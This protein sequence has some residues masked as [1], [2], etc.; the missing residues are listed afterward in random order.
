MKSEL[1]F[2]TFHRVYSHRIAVIEALNE[3][4]KPSGEALNAFKKSTKDFEFSISDFANGH[5]EDAYR[6]FATAIKI[7]VPL[8]EWYHAVRN[9]EHEA[10]RFLTSANLKISEL[11]KSQSFMETKE[12]CRFLKKVSELEDFNQVNELQEILKAW[13]LPLILFASLRPARL[14]ISKQHSNKSNNQK[15]PLDT[16]VAFLK[17]DID[18]EPAKKWN[19]LKPNLAYDLTIEVR[20]SNWPDNAKQ[21]RLI[22]ITLD[23]Y[24]RDWLPEFTFQ[25]P[26]GNGPHILTGTNRALLKTANSFGSRP[27]EFLYA[28]EFDDA[29]TGNRVE[30]IGHRRLLIEGND[31]AS[32]PLTGFTNVDLQLLNIRN[33]LRSFPGLG[34]D[35]LSNAMTVLGGLGSIAGNA[36]RSSIFK[37]N[38]PEREFQT[39]TSKMLRMRPDI[40][41]DLQGHPEAAGGIT[42]LTFRDI[43]IE[44]K[45]ENS[46]V[47]H[48][49]DFDGF[50]D[51]TTAYAL[52]LGKRIGILAVLETTPKSSPIGNIEDDIAAFTHQVGNS[53]V[54]IVVVVVRGG[55]PK[56]SS[57]SKG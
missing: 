55:L 53:S 33:Q 12:L 20:V 28:A 19:Y 40:G 36:L 41:E 11:D 57:Y 34:H 18:G 10:N 4:L 44:L 13:Q 9:A 25:K 27:Y 37:P 26:I 38:T 29:S 39:E 3:A 47:L 46:K 43:P 16:T 56:P 6:A 31:S 7:F 15:K 21:L 54:A 52:G 50:F 2:D 8:A 23:R 51:Q 22:P 49:K 30:T 35:D 17:F 1:N 48:P 24:E 42:D 45:V 14:P 32:N 5:A